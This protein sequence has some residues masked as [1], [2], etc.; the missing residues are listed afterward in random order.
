MQLSC[1][2]VEDGYNFSFLSSLRK[3]MVAKAMDII[4]GK[5]EKVDR[6][7]ACPFQLVV[8]TNIFYFVVLCE[9]FK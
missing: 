7:A 2:C 5:N 4:L 3:L 9:V 1:F 8:N 6:L